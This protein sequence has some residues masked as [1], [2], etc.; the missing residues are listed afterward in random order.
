MWNEGLVIP[1]ILFQWIRRVVE[2]FETLQMPKYSNEVHD[3]LVRPFRLPQGERSEC[4]QEASKV[5]SNPWHEAGD[6]QVVY[7]ESLD[8]RQRK[9]WRRLKQ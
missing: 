5:P 9:K 1:G 6:V 2:K 8:I 7:P 4:W 3:L